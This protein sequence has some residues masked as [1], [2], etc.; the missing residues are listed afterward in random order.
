M[1]VNTAS[2]SV[3]SAAVE[4][5]DFSDSDW[6]DVTSSHDE[7]DAESLPIHEESDTDSL[8]IS[9]REHASSRSRR[10]SYSIDSESLDGWEGFVDDGVDVPPTD[11][12]IFRDEP[13]DADRRVNDALDQ[14]M[15]STLSASHTDTASCGSL[16]ASTVQNSSNDLRLSFPDPL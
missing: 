5:E 1:S 10:S 15:A 11:I 13:S 16:H 8:A 7:S 2:L 9:I 14:G 12:P 6:L 4:G 3:P